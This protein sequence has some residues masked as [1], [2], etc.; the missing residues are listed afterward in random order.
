MRRIIRSF[1]E[2]DSILEHIS[3]TARSPRLELYRPLV[4]KDL[5]EID[6]S[7]KNTQIADS[8]TSAT[9]TAMIPLSLAHSAVLDNWNILLTNREQITPVHFLRK[10]K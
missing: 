10:A 4:V 9:Q 8:K 7:P 3:Q 5:L 1:W 6:R 2:Q